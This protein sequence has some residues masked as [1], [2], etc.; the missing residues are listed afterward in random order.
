[1]DFSVVWDYLVSSSCQNEQVISRLK[2][3][4]EVYRIMGMTL[5][6][7]FSSFSTLRFTKIRSSRILLGTSNNLA[8]ILVIDLN[9]RPFQNYSLF[10]L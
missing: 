3:Q 1:V 9:N 7:Y 4:L 10:S 5:G 8:L 2:S 6:S